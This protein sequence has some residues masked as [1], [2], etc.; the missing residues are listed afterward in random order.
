MRKVTLLIITLTLALSTYAQSYRSDKFLQE[1]RL[2]AGTDKV[3]TTDFDA[4]SKIATGFERKAFVKQLAPK[5]QLALW[6]NHYAYVLATYPLTPEQEALVREAAK[7]FLT[8]EFFTKLREPN[9]RDSPLQK[10]LD[11]FQAR[12]VNVFTPYPELYR[13]IFEI[14]GTVPPEIV[15]VCEL[16]NKAAHN[17]MVRYDGQIQPAKIVLASF[18]GCDPRYKTCFGM[19]ECDCN[20]SIGCG[21]WGC[22]GTRCMEVINCGVFG[23]STCGYKCGV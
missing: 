1:L 12:V 20:Y 8:V 6:Q 17:A 21:N 22:T 5:R 10:E 3:D 14:P 9:Y 23:G 15:S 16:K 7:R 18:T 4:V 2:L 13:N 11:E 19:P